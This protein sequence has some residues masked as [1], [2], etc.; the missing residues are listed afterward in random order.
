MNKL[1][2]MV[3]ELIGENVSSPDVFQD[4]DA[5]LEPIRDSLNDA[6]QE[7]VMLTGSKKSEYYLPLREGHMFYRLA[8]TTGNLGWITDAWLVSQQYRLE[9]SDVIKLSAYD[10]LWM[11][12]SAQ[13]RAY[14]QLG[15]DVIGIWPKPS[16]SSGLLRLT[17]VE[18]PDAYEGS[19]DRIN[20]RRE[21]EHA[22]SNYAVA[23]YWASRGDAQQAATFFG[24]YMDTLGIGDQ[25]SEDRDR[26]PGGQ[27][28]K[29]PWPKETG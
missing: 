5:G 2:T 14:F 13:P 12:V 19:G 28:R 7:I 29:D 17:I 8:L 10:P 3:L 26:T 6:I 23:E 27:T 16:G 11:K 15:A 4:T 24:Y 18:I 9:Q 25:A 1:E 21:Y 20:L 22:A